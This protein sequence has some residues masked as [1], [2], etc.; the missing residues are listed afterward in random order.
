MSPPK[1]HRTILVILLVTGIVQ[2]LE[3]HK[4]NTYWSKRSGEE[5][6]NYMEED[7]SQP[8]LHWAKNFDKYPL[9]TIDHRQEMKENKI[10]QTDGLLRLL[11]FLVK[12]DKRGRDVEK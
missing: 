6:E 5:P 12:Q 2:A 1:L 3:R 9:S 4:P 7:K 11:W 10:S 8:A